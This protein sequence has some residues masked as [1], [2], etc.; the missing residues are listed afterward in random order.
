MKHTRTKSESSEREKKKE[1]LPQQPS[2]CYWRVFRFKCF[3]YSH[4][5]ILTFFSSSSYR[6]L[7]STFSVKSQK[8]ER[9]P[10]FCVIASSHRICLHSFTS[11]F[12]P[13]CLFELRTRIL[14]FHVYFTIHVIKRFVWSLNKKQ[15]K[16]CFGSVIKYLHNERINIISINKHRQNRFFF[17]LCRAYYKF[18]VLFICVKISFNQYCA[19]FNNIC[20]QIHKKE[21]KFVKKSTTTTT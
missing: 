6:W 10:F 8:K 17:F 19:Y 15:K 21:K 1:M 14:F 2:N 16:R 12:K 5:S 11:P 7:F 4:S 3:C 18:S 20:K 13:D 9:N